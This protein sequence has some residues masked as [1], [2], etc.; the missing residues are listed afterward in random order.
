MVETKS[1]TTQIGVKL[2][3][4]LRA[5]LESVARRERNGLSA[6]ARR[7]LSEAIQREEE[8]HRQPAPLV[9]R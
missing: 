6:V 8:A 3:A 7:L 4:E 1:S 5:R 2:P 9:L